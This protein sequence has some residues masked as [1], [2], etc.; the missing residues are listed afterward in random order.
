MNGACGSTSERACRRASS[1]GEIA[2]TITAAP[3]R[4]TREATQPMRW[5][6]SSRSAFEKPRPFERCVRTMSPSRWSTTWPRCSSSASTMFATVVL[7]APERPVNQTTKPLIVAAPAPAKPALPRP[8]LRLLGAGPA[9]LA[10]LAGER[11]VRVPDRVVALIVQ[12][13]VRQPALADVGPALLVRPVGERVRLPELV[14]LVPPE[15]RRG[16]AGRRLV[17]AD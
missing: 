17:A 11:R 7:P 16:R 15:L 2:E 12:R 4:A 6:F 13:V 5:M 8:A 9:A 1:Y 3:A 10:P 14:L